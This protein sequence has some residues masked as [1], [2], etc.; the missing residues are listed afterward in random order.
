MEEN[1][2]FWEAV[3]IFVIKL[4]S[5]EKR[6]NIIEEDKKLFLE[7]MRKKGYL[8]ID[9]LDGWF[10]W[11]IAYDSNRVLKEIDRRRLNTKI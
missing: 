6:K 2:S 10:D 5:H 9:R 1:K 8:N 3:R 11:L 7:F 4:R